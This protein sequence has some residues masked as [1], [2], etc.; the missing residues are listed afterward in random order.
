MSDLDAMFEGWLWDNP[1]TRDDL[2][3]TRP[4]FGPWVEHQGRECDPTYR[5][6]EHI[7]SLRDGDPEKWARL[8]KDWTAPGADRGLISVGGE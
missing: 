7:A 2:R 3:Q 5:L 6:E 1:E 4:G 8:N